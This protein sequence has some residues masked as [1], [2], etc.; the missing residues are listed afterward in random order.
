MSHI[1]NLP[2]QEMIAGVVRGATEKMASHPDDWAAKIAMDEGATEPCA[3]GNAEC[4]GECTSGDTSDIT[5]PDYVEKLASVCDFL[6]QNVQNI[7]VPNRGVLGNA[8][9]KLAGEPVPSPAGSKGALETTTGMA[10]EQQY[11]KDKPKPGYDASASTASSPEGTAGLPAGATQMENDMESAPGQASGSIPTA[12]YPAAGVFH[13]GPTK[14]AGGKTDAAKELLQKLKGKGSSF[15]ESLK[16]GKKQP[17]LVGNK[18]VDKRPGNSLTALKMKTGPGLVARNSA[19]A[20]AAL[21]GGAVV[22]GGGAATLASKGKEASAGDLA[23]QAVLAK[24][25]GEDVMKSNISS[26]KAG[27]PSPGDGEMDALEASQVPSNPTDGSG[28]G[29]EGRSHIQSNTAAQ[30]YTKGDA[31]KP[32]GKQ[33][34]E[35]LR[36]PAFSQKHDGKLQEQLQNTGKAGVKIAGAQMREFLK[37][38]AANGKLTQEMVDGIR[39]TA[40]HTEGH[41]EGCTCGGEG[42]CKVCKLKALKE[43]SSKTSMGDMGEMGY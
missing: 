10:G 16:G 36:N 31:K 1:S 41:A 18:V 5:D 35:V 15:V 22:A 14:T 9:A 38:A 4:S 32:Q 30:S 42:S 29:N 28:Y 40:E 27:G 12:K 3:C 6:A 19:K 2:L 13:S 43:E 39:K 37:Q 17:F 7:E 34:A 25:A 33:M 23:R 24:L 20:R 8:I 21:A 11:K 26:P